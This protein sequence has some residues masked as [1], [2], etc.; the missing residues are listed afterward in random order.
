MICFQYRK[1]EHLA[2]NCTE[3]PQEV[4]QVVSRNEGIVVESSMAAPPKYKYG[5]WMLVQKT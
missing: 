1:Y 3:K 4:I 2:D 5:N